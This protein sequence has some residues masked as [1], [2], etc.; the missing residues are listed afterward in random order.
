MR[1][2]SGASHPGVMLFSLAA[3]NTANNRNHD[4]MHIISLNLFEIQ[5]L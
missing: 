2:V 4:E 3:L 1:N 5:S